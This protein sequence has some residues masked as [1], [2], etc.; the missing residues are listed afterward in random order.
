MKFKNII[1]GLGIFVVYALVLWQGIQAF[2]PAPEYN[3]YCDFRSQYYYSGA[4]PIAKPIGV[5]EN[6]TVNPSQ[7]EYDLCVQQEG[8]LVAGSYDSYGCPLNFEC[9]TCNKIFN[10]AQDGYSRNVF[11]I[12]LIVGLLTF[13]VGFFVL[14]IEPVGSALLASGLWAIV[15]GTAFNWRNFGNSLRFGILLLVLLALIWIAMRLNKEK[16]KG[17]FFGIRFGK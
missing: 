7:Q 16:K 14:K 6:C 3:D 1:L 5:G 11:I 2:Y 12:S 13:V 17:F 9:D 4:Y 15:Y 8:N 10:E